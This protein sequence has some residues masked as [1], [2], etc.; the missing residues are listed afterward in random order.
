MKIERR[1]RR[2]MQQELTERRRIGTLEV[3]SV[4]AVGLIAGSN[5]AWPSEYFVVRFVAWGAIALLSTLA[6]RLAFAQVRSHAQPFDHTLEIGEEGIVR[7]DNLRKLRDEFTWPEVRRVR[8]D[9]RAFEFSFR[10][11]RQGETYLLDRAKLTDDESAFVA[12]R[13]LEL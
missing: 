11:N 12:E 8:I 1:F 5:T 9:K 3:L 6:L 10:E 2:T 4:L 13:L 7:V